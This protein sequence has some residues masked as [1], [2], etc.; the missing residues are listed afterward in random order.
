[1]N[2]CIFGSRDFD[3]YEMLEFAIDEY[4]KKHR[5]DEIISGCAKGADALGERYADEH[6]IKVDKNP[7]D[8]NLHGKSAGYK[9]NV[10]MA[11]KC[12]VAI[13]FWDGESKGTKQMIDYVKSLGKPC[14]VIKY[15]E[16]EI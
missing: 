15:K 6:Q 1:M 12:D 7:A 13:G 10:I 5:V 4:R 11:K 2:L 14:Y 8:W 9:R 16:Y 3:N